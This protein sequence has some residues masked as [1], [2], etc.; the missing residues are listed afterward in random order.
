MSKENRGIGHNQNPVTEE[1]IEFI[2][3]IYEDLIVQQKYCTEAIFGK[4]KTVRNNNKVWADCHLH[5]QILNKFRRTDWVVTKWDK[6]KGKEGYD[7]K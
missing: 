6:P 2:K 5:N 4:N 1:A 3:S 7:K